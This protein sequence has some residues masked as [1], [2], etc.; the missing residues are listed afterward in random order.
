MILIVT[1]ILFSFVILFWIAYELILR[2]IFKY[3]KYSSSIEFPDHLFKVVE[4]SDYEE[5]VNI[6]L[7]K[8]NTQSIIFTGL[9]YNLESTLQTTINRLH[10]IGSHFK[11]YKIVIYENNSTDKTK[12]IL[13]SN[14]GPNFIFK[15]ENIPNIT[16]ARASGRHSLKR[17]QLMAKYRTEYQMLIS[18]ITDPFDQVLVLDMDIRCGMSLEGI[19]HSYSFDSWDMIACNGIS[20]L[21]NKYYDFLAFKDE[22]GNRINHHKPEESPSISGLF[23]KN[24]RFKKG[25]SI[26]SV[27]SA[28][29]GAAIYQK[30]AFLAGTYA[31]TDCEHICFHESLV[32]K[33]YS[34]LF[35]N[36]S[37]MVVR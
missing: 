33:G 36:P 16:S 28:F 25:D 9:A 21:T 31:G 12:D 13:N 10:Y 8:I 18:E 2:Y 7:K 35:S 14:I 19:A 29:G 32:E 3:H 5:R 15:S 24:Y 26:L 17:Y 11:D 34:N 30:D 27:R 4:G 1:I 6:G 20:I 37:F 22:D 23:S